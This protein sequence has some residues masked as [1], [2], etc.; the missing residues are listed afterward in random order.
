MAPTVV[1]CGVCVAA[2]TGSMAYL[3]IKQPW[4]YEKIRKIPQAAIEL[5]VEPPAKSTPRG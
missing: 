1:V 3:S 2:M 4:T 5:F